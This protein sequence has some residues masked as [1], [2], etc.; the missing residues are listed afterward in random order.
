MYRLML[1][2]V[3]AGLAACDAGSVYM[4]KTAD[5]R[6]SE[7]RAD[8]YCEMR[9][10]FA[11]LQQRGDIDVYRCIPRSYRLTNDVASAELHE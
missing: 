6:D 1:S 3:L 5:L 10:G 7:Q 8:R 9:N 4:I 11:Q 2:L